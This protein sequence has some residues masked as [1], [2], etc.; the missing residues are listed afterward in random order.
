MNFCKTILS[1]LGKGIMQLK[2]YENSFNNAFYF[3]SSGQIEIPHTIYY[4]I[5]TMGHF[6]QRC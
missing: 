2:S 3:V 6:L 5:Q 1:N 4:N